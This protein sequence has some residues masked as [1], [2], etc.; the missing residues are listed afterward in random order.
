MGATKMISSR[1]VE[2]ND[3]AGKKM[4]PPLLAY[5]LRLFLGRFG[6]LRRLYGGFISD[7]PTAAIG[8]IVFTL[9][10][11][12]PKRSADHGHIAAASCVS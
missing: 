12:C 5:V 2:E 10:R 11:V 8:T 9:I 7:P 6:S 3:V 4:F 1:K